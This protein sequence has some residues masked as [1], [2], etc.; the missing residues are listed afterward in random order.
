[1]AQHVQFNRGRQPE[2]LNKLTRKSTYVRVDL[3]AKMF[4]ITCAEFL[5]QSH[6]NADCDGT[7]FLR[8]RQGADPSF[9]IEVVA[10]ARNCGPDQA[11]VF[12]LCRAGVNARRTA[13]SGTQRHCNGAKR[14]CLRRISGLLTSRAEQNTAVSAERELSAR[15]VFN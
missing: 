13:Q 12:R 8:L 14:D 7:W 3:T 11:R 2:G 6:R 15:E 9:R 1:M 10:G 4:W 5:S